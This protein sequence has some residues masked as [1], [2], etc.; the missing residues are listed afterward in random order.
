MLSK[1]SSRT[2]VRIPEEEGLII[3]LSSEDDTRT[4]SDQTLFLIREGIKARGLKLVNGTD[5]KPSLLRATDS[6]KQK[7]TA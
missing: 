2:M 5:G 1:K 6:S 7:R 3:R 4:V